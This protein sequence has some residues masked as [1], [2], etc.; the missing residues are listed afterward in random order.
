VIRNLILDWSGTLVDDLD[1][2]VHATNAVLHAYGRAALSR[3]DFRRE[4]ELPIARFYR[5]LLPDVALTDIDAAYHECFAQ[6]RETVSLLPYAQA[7]LSFCA[8]TGRR[9]FLLSTMDA[10]HFQVQSVRLGV[11]AAFEGVYP[12]TTDKTA[13]IADVLHRH[14]LVAAETAFVGDMVHDVEAGKTA[15]VTSVAVLT[16]FDTR[17][18]LAGAGPDLLVRDLG[19]L[20]RFMEA[21]AG[22]VSERIEINDLEVTTHI[23]VLPEEQ[24]LP[25]KL[26]LDVA[27]EIARPFAELD[28]ALERTVD[29]TAVADAVT[30]FSRTNRGRLIETFA[31]R[32]ADLVGRRFPVRRV[33][34]AVKKVV[35]PN[36]R[37][38]LVRT[39]YTGK[40]SEYRGVGVTG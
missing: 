25:Q 11:H 10:G 14:Q 1:A 6:Y 4:F 12:A 27:F 15:G 38:V 26:W 20:E 22:A 13:C 24:D 39:G 30:D 34:I 35:L 19:V 21:A 16:G 28:D 3:E 37:H 23:G 17:E 2:V 9:L 7:F 18:K 8:A 29:Y 36:T 33:E 5:R 32:L 40:V 31:V